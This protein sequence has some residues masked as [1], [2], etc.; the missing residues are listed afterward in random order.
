[1]VTLFSQTLVTAG[2]NIEVEGENDTAPIH[3]AAQEGHSTVVAKLAECGANM[4]IRDGDFDTPLHLAA[5]G[6]DGKGQLEV[7]CTRTVGFH[8]RYH[9]TNELQVVET[10]LKVGADPRAKRR[11]GKTAG[12]TTKNK[13]AKLHIPAPPPSHCTFS[14]IIRAL[15]GT[16]RVAPCG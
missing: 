11:N 4:E 7:P 9:D 15:S 12:M 10:L 6:T 8:R 14:H 2:A 13:V 1:M 3:L 5:C 16:S